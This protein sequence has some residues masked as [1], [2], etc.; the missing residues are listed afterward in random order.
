MPLVLWSRKFVSLESLYP[1]M[2]TEIIWVCI[3]NY[4]LLC[5]YMNKTKSV[6][7]V[8]SHRTDEEDNYSYVTLPEVKFE[9]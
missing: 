1:E 2:S 6:R 7:T 5:F 3:V 9:L 4:I 8:L